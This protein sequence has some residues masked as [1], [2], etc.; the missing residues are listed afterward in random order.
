MPSSRNGQEASTYK[1]VGLGYGVQIC[2]GVWDT[3]W[4]SGFGFW[5]LGIGVEGFVHL[6]FYLE[7]WDLNMGFGFLV[8]EYGFSTDP[9]ASPRPTSSTIGYVLG[10]GHWVW[11]L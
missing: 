6:W 7:I 10:F 9:P 3:C 8:V 1:E 11:M 2:V 4:G 5:G